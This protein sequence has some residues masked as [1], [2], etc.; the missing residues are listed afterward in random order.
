MSCAWAPQTR[1]SGTSRWFYDYVDPRIYGI[2]YTRQPSP[3]I[4]D[5]AAGGIL[6]LRK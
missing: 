1:A 3:W 2:R 6:Q 4:G 5:L